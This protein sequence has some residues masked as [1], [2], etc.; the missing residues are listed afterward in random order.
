MKK[1][2][3][4][5]EKNTTYLCPYKQQQVNVHTLTYR[6]YKIT[7]PPRCDSVDYSCP[8]DCTYK[9]NEENL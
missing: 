6:E 4:L 9:Q 3:P 2:T 5:L 1:T 7:L 8:N